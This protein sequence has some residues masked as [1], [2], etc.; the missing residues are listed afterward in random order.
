MLLEIE[1]K[2]KEILEN[3]ELLELMQLL[4]IMV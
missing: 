2:L 4:E 3:Y 1:S